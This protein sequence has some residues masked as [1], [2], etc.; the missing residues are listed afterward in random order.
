ML[1]QPSLRGAKPT[2][3][4]QEALAP[5]GLTFELGFLRASV[6]G[7]A[8]AS[9]RAPVAEQEL[10]AA[11]EWYET[12][13]PGLGVE[14]LTALQTAFAQ[15]ESSPEA[16]PSRG[17]RRIVEWSCSASRMRSS[18][19]LTDKHIAVR[20]VAHAKRRPEYWHLV[21]RSASAR[22]VRCL[23]QRE[24]PNGTAANHSEI[25]HADL[26]DGAWSARACSS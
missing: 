23:A 6:P 17:H 12:K 18:T 15:V 24:R 5:H 9:H 19:F 21:D 20:A 26:L 10:V 22:V 3:S 8:R 2:S 11:A 7:E 4:E 14:F 16:W 13:R 1:G 25:E